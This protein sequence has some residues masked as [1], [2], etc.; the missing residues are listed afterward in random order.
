MSLARQ[1]GDRVRF[2]LIGYMDRE[3]GPWQSDDAVFTVHGRYRTRDLP[4]LFAHYRV[5]LVMFP[6]AGPETFSFTLSEAWACARAVLV[7]PIGALAERVREHG[8][9]W[10]WTDEEWRSEVRML[11]AALARLAPDARPELMRVAAG[12]A[13]IRTTTLQEMAERTA[14]VYERT[15]SPT[16][17]RAVVPGLDRA[18][19]RDA[20]GYR[21]WYPPIPPTVAETPVRPA[22]APGARAPALARWLQWLRAS[23]MWRVLRMLTPHPVRT[24]VRTRL[25]S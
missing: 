3:H 15:L 8:G 16:R 18:R 5:Q 2:V 21:L 13:R 11:D 25:W 20:L 10:V 4:D 24:A 6:S 23:R 12:A 17:E 19:L 7:P 22:N 1:R 9:G 14:S